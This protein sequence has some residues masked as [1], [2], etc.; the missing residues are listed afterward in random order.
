MSSLGGH[1]REVVTYESLA[2]TG[3]KFGLR[4]CEKSI[5]KKNPVL[6]LSRNP[7]RNSIMLQCLS[8]IQFQL[9]FLKASKA[10]F[11]DKTISQSTTLAS[12]LFI[13]ELVLLVACRKERAIFFFFYPFL[14]LVFFIKNHSNLCPADKICEILLAI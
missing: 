4:I 10:M 6:V 14:L 12:L 1:I 5:S 3:S 8:I 13:P 2:N 9:A 7:A 11:P